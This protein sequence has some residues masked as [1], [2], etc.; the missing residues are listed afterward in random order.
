MKLWIIL[1]IYTSRAS[2]MKKKKEMMNGFV[3]EKI[4]IFL[5]VKKNVF[6]DQNVIRV[7]FVFI[8]IKGSILN[9]QHLVVADILNEAEKNT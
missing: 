1:G 7:D 9:I 8:Q 3:G 4:N 6:K 2:G 5:K